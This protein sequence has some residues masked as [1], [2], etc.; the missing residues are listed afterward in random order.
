MWIGAHRPKLNYPMN[1]IH[2]APE[3]PESL[4][5]ILDLINQKKDLVF[6]CVIVAAKAQEPWKKLK[7]SWDDPAQKLWELAVDTD[8]EIGNLD[9]YLVV[10][11]PNS[12]F[13]FTVFTA[14]NCCGINIG[15]KPGRYGETVTR[16]LAAN[17]I[18]TCL[19]EVDEPTI[20]GNY[21]I[22]DKNLKSPFAYHHER[23]APPSP[24]CHRDRKNKP[25]P[26][27]ITAYRY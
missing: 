4:N 15:G 20:D 18:P 14:P 19:E 21:P 7:S 26:A 13:Q 10:R 5:F 6:G 11:E 2:L 3:N 27:P 24:P 25:T 12:V 1:F 17:E 16:S 22:L 8:F 9:V 23:P